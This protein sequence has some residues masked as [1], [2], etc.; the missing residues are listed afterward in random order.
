MNLG[1][2]QHA[3]EVRQL[4][5]RGHWPQ[6]CPAELRAHAATCRTCGEV[7]LLTETFRGARAASLPTPQLPPAGVLWWRA[8]LRRRNAAVQRINK[9]I[10]GALM[11]SFSVTLIVAFLFAFSQAKQSWL[12]FASHGAGRAGWF[13]S[14]SQS[15]AFHFQSLLPLTSIMSSGSL[16]YLV[17]G[18]ALLA[19]FSGVV[20]YLASDKQ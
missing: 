15:P 5:E 16:M 9:P 17:P 12:W 13:A 7:I 4:L 8:Q 14:V 10:L 11:F 19:L 6:S 20:L 2:C 18:V 3:A 1:T